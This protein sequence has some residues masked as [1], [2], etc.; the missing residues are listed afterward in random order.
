MRL[1]TFSI[2]FSLIF[3]SCPFLRGETLADMLGKATLNYA[4]RIE[5][6]TKELSLAREKISKEKTPLVQATNAASE[7]I[8]AL[9]SE[10]TRLETAQARAL[11]R[12]QKL[13]RD[14][15]T[16]RKNLNYVTTVAQDGL[17]NLES[18]LLPGEGAFY[19]DRIQTLRQRNENSTNPLDVSVALD[20]MEL[21]L[22]RV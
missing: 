17:K 13:Q 3:L 22:E 8:T 4:Q 15:D 5:T 2:A 20:S 18:S 11:E 6:A 10:I 19:N 12:R 7:R 14:L 16:L 9:E 1:K 21:V